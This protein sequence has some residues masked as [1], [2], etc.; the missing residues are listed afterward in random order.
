ML[1]PKNIW[2]DIQLYKSSYL[3]DARIFFARHVLICEGESDKEF[4]EAVAEA[5]G[6]NADTYEDI[7][8]S[9]M[10]KD[11][12]PRYKNVLDSL[13]IPYVVVADSDNDEE[14]ALRKR[15]ERYGLTEDYMII[16]SGEFA[17]TLM[18][19]VFFFKGDV[20]E[21]MR[22]QNAEL[23]NEVETS[24]TENGL[25][26]CKPAFMHEYVRHLIKKSPH[27]IDSTIIPLLNYAFSVNT[28]RPDLTL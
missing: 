8:I 24:L 25:G 28:R 18:G 11:N 3:I 1:D 7:V 2:P 14:T 10:S 9:A 20:E 17:K 19:K 12:I 16:D 26:G 22:T 13:A 15:A 21:F 5:F 6:F 23:Y 27:S 4:L